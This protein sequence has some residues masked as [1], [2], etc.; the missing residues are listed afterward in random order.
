[1]ENNY[2]RLLEAYF[3]GNLSQ[4]EQ[5]K[6]KT[7]L[8]SDPDFAAEF[9]WRQEV[10]RAVRTGAEKDPTYLK[11]KELERRFRFRKLTLQISAAAAALILLILAV[12]F[13]PSIFESKNPIATTQDSL[14]QKP[15]P[16]LPNPVI[17]NSAA[18]KFKQDSIEAAEKMKEQERKEQ[19]ERLNKKKLQAAIQ[20]AAIQKEIFA[21]LEH[22][23][24]TS[25]YNNAAGVKTKDPL[26]TLAMQAYGLY[27]D[28]AYKQAAQ[29]FK[30][31]VEADPANVENQFYYGFSL[32]ADKQFAAAAA[33]F[34]VTATGEQS[35][36]QASAKFYIG[37][38]HSGAG[39]FKAGRQAFQDY[40]AEPPSKIRQFK[41]L[42][43]NMLKK[44]PSQ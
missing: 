2:E 16:A 38:A 36:Y 11:L 22:Y 42:A 39:E 29:I 30:R 21:N 7:L 41:G 3:A 4:A 6:M 20:K 15:A 9:A 28:K 14:F 33:A 10:A 13:A 31:V 8:A 18:E 5:T 37:M 44:L 19:E 12:K 34:Q 26:T 24:N 27:N 40:L 43:E 25:L 17:Q 35:I 23:P 32:L 1:M